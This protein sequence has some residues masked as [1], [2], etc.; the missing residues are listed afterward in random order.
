MEVCTVPG[1]ETRFFT[2]AT[3]ESRHKPA[4]ETQHTAH[5]GREICARKESCMRFATGIR[6]AL[7]I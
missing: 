7:Q 4:R 2:Q 6:R 3:D 5:A 1:E